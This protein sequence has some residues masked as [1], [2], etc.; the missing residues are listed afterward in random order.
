[1]TN[2]PADVSCTVRIRVDPRRGERDRDRFAVAG[3][4]VASPAGWASM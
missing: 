2:P 1:M 4:G 3:V